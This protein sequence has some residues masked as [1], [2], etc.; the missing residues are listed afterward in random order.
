MAGAP[1][2]LMLKTLSTLRCWLPI[3]AG[4]LLSFSVQATLFEED[5]PLE[6]WLSGPLDDLVDGRKK[7]EAHSF[8][9]RVGNM[10]HTVQLSAR[11]KSR[12]EICR[13]PP[14]RITFVEPPPQD[15]PSAGQNRRKLVTH[16]RDVENMRVNVLEE[17]A[18][19]QVFS[20]MTSIGYRTRLLRI[21]YED[22]AGRLDGTHY[23]FAIESTDGLATRLGGKERELPGVSRNRLDQDHLALVSVFHYLVGN[24]DWSLVV[25]DGDDACCHNGKLVSVGKDLFLIPYDYDRTGLVDASYAEPASGARIRKVTQRRYRGY[26]SD[27]ESQLRAAVRLTLKLQPDIERTVAELPGLGDRDI[28]KNQSFLAE[29][30]DKA[31]DVDKLVKEFQRHCLD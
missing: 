30:F 4:T 3:F 19:Y 18:A 16:C 14:L 29:Y 15:S 2:A 1:V 12:L 24:T 17:F 9:L 7:E 31:S 27:N 8:T 13:F 11:G 10:T 26:C 28:E 5:E 6:L 25:A 23:A 22:T 21:H 20:L